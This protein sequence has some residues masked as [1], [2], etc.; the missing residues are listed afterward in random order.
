[1]AA[2]T[3]SAADVIDQLGRSHG[4][5][6]H[7]AGKLNTTRT[8]LHKYINEHPT[9]AAALADIREGAKDDAELMLYDQMRT[10]PTLLIFFLK[11]Q[12]RDRGYSDT[13][14][15]TGKDGGDIAINFVDYRRGLA[16]IAPED[17]G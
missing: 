13:L 2:I 9:V 7:A 17:E 16:A 6:K 14:A 15:L 10:N 11:T 3:V 5:I 8:T 1:M 4:N 12:A